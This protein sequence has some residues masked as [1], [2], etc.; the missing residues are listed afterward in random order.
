[1]WKIKNIRHSLVPGEGKSFIAANLSAILSLT[2]KEKKV[3]IVEG[4]L[5]KPKLN[6]L[7]G[8]N[9]GIGLSTYLAN[10]NN[11]Q[12]IILQSPF[13]NLF[14]VPA[15]EIPPNP[16]ELLENGRFDSF[17]EE[18]RSQFDYVIV[19][20]APL[21]LVP[22]SLMTSKH[23]DSCL[24]IIRLNYSKKNELKEINKI[25]AVNTLKNAIIV[26]NDARRTGLDMET[27]I[28][29]KVTVII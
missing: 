5:R 21:S 29:R 20:N 9:E 16:T 26:I 3:L 6:I 7:F 23:A 24:F 4:D 18:V 19:D 22:D 17:I 2:T 1:M 12:E 25:V 28:G 15:G 10:N 8:D 13:P 11:I 14:F 27:N